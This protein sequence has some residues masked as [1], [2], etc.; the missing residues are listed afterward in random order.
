MAGNINLSD[1]GVIVKQTPREI[2]KE[3]D[4]KV[5]ETQEQKER[6]YKLLQFCHSSTQNNSNPALSFYHHIYTD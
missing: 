1:A 3:R 4:W 5:N 2:L 6:K